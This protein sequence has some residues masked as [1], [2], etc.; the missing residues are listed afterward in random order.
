MESSY[1]VAVVGCGLVGSA[2]GKYLAESGLKVVLIG[3][4]ESREVALG[5]FGCHADEGRITRALDVDSVWAELAT[6]SMVRYGDIEKRSGV[7]FH[8]AVGCLAVGR[9]HSPYLSAV[10]RTAERQGVSVE[11]LDEKAM[12]EKWPS[13]RLDASF[14][15]DS[16][17]EDSD[18]EKKEEYAGLYERGAAGHVSPRKLLQAQLKLFEKAGGAVINDVVLAVNS[19]ILTLKETGPLRAKK[20]LI[21]TNAMTNFADLLP[22]K[23]KLTLTTQTAVRRRVKEPL[24][25]M[26]SIIIK[27]GASPFGTKAQKLDACYILP[28]V[29]YDKDTYVKIGH[30]TFFERDLES[31]EELRK[32]YSHAEDREDA[33]ARC[34]LAAL[35]ERLFRADCLEGENVITRCVIPKTPTKRPYLHRFSPSLACCVGCNGYAAKSSDEL[36]RLAASMLLEGAPGNNKWGPNIPDDAFTI[37]FDD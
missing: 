30:G 17:D 31:L 19:E 33:Q 13:L 26:P 2:A 14:L 36:G 23:V 37:V 21:A 7:E 22:R 11:E 9:R 34:D 24:T 35:L 18:L 3:P 20:I 1:D 15:R 32:W 8:G 6:R 25:T 5:T 29:S 12:R 4:S 16:D 28:P 10:K 27:A